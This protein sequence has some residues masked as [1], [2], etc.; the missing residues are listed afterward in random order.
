MPGVIIDKNY[1]K[2]CELCVKACPQQILSM[3]KEIT[4]RGYLSAQMHDPSRCIGCQI[5]A[6]V[7][8]DAAIT[9][10]THGQRYML[11]EY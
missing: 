9:V 6:L 8:P 10:V 7:C 1:C 3:S 5:C 2:G 11:Y 4:N